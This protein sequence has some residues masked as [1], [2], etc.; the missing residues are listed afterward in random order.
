MACV[1]AHIQITFCGTVSHG[2]DF[3]NK[4]FK[5]TFKLVKL[6]GKSGLFAC[7]LP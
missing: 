3:G 2:R 5:Q 6:L 4:A 1:C 7:H